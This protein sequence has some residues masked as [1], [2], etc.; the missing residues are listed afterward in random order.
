MTGHRRPYVDRP[1]DDVAVADSVAREAAAALGLTVPGRAPV[2]V[3]VGMNALYECGDTVLRVGRPSAPAALAIALAE[4]LLELGVAVPRPAGDR[5]YEAD[6][7]SVTAWHRIEPS[8]LPIDWGEVGRI[9]RRVHALD[10][11]DI[12]AGYPLPSPTGFPWWDFT[13]VR[14]DIADHIDPAA[15][16]G[17][18]AAI[19]RHRDWHELVAAGPVV[20]HGDVHP[21]NVMMTAAGP[22]LLD[23]DLMCLAHPG[24]DHAMLLTLAERWGGD[25]AVY[26]AFAVGYGRSLAGDPAARAFAELRNV[27]ATLMRV[28]AGIS[29]PAARAEAERRLRHWRGDPTAPAWSAQ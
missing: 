10:A 13:S 2:R 14:A 19:E 4:R 5:A 22:V 15:L 18:D 25:P 16:A 24:W 1:V 23:W 11:T 28:R 3:R 6:G 21:G 17:L 7:M 26:P 12:P 27:A 8:P 20:C 29:D 9:V